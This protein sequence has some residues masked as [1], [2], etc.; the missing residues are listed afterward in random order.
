MAQFLCSCLPFTPLLLFNI[1][2]T[3]YTPLSTKKHE[4]I[5]LKNS[6][7]AQTTHLASFGLLIVVIA[8]IESLHTFR[9]S[10]VPN[11]IIK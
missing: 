4:G 6:P 8:L 9:V 3:L 10:V 11:Y 2:S 5:F 1:N 7:T